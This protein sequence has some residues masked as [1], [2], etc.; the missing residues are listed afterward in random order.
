MWS[1]RNAAILLESIIHYP[2]FL[3]TYWSSPF[4]HC[5]T[6]FILTDFGSTFYL[7]STLFL[8]F[9]LDHKIHPWL[10]IILPTPLMYLWL[11]EKN[12]TGLEKKQLSL[13][14]YHFKF[15]SSNLIW[16]YFMPLFQ[17]LS[18]PQDYFIASALSL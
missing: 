2:L 5:Q 11:E 18:L 15:M 7:H 3:W 10:I 8:M 12:K 17:S 6:V 4:A 13:L 1:S 14:M 9:Y 16:P